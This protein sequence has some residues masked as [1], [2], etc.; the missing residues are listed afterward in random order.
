MEREMEFTTLGLILAIILIIAFVLLFTRHNQAGRVL[1]DVAVFLIL[2]L[3]L[4]G[5]SV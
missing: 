1:F 3:L 4:L 5:V 2:L